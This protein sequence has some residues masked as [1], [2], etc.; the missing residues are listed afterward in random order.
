M[1]GVGD[2]A[3]HAVADDDQAAAEKLE[4]AQQNLQG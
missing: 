3:G 2:G 4:I 1:Y